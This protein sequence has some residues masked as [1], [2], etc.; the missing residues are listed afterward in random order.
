MSD[1]LNSASLVMIPSGYKE[2]IVYSAV[3]TDGSGDLSFTRA[4]NGTRVN[5]AGLVEVCPWNLLE[6]SEDLTNAYWQKNNVTISSNTTVAPNG[7]TTADTL[8]NSATGYGIFATIDVI[9]S[10]QY[11]FSFYIKKGTN[12]SYLLSVIDGST[13]TSI[14]SLDYSSQVSASDWVRITQTFTIPSS[15]TL[16]RVYQ[17]RDGSTT[18]TAFI[19]AHN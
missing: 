15:T 2:D 14:A 16:I 13:F 3:P 5:S 9:P 1:L 17:M 11:T 12:T 8:T 19:W 10:Q 18:G 4:S 6:Y 7:T